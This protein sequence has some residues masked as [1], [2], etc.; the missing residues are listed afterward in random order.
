MIRRPP[1]STL[2]PYT[3]LF[4]SYLRETI[5]AAGSRARVASLGGRYFGMDRDRRWDRTEKFYRPMVNGVGPTTTDPLRAI[6]DA[7]DRGET[8]EFITPAVV[9]DAAGAPLAPM[10][11]GDAVICF[12]YRSDRM[13]Q[14]VRALMRD[15]FDG[16]DV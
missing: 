2:F 6:Q 15:G 9:V 3:T 4:R 8:D 10:R 1:R 11:D 14:I 16:F 5:A 12:N 7:Y 13:R